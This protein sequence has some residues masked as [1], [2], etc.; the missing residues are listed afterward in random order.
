MR[1]SVGNISN[2]VSNAEFSATVHAVARQVNQDFAPLWGMDADV[3]GVAMKR[4][5]KPNPELTMSDVI[6]YVGELDDDPQKV[7][8]AV[9]YHDLNNKGIPYGFV[10]TDIAA[11]T[12]DKWS[13]TLSHEVLELLADPDVNLLVVGPNP[14][15]PKGVALR[16]YE[17]CDPVQADSYDI[18]GIS[19]SNFVTP[20]YFARLPSP[21]TTRTNY[22]NL[23]LDRFGV[24]PGGYFSYFDLATKK[25]NDV[26]G[27][28]AEARQRAKEILGIARRMR[29]HAGLELA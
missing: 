25:W 15:N 1:I 7:A 28:G 23:G 3:R 9:G 21:T 26:F 19:V 12:G 13:T 22:L 5:S 29:R 20:L 6:L 11:K 4:D 24:R 18:D 2:K 8:N 16:S 27:H 17:V 10:F 14:K